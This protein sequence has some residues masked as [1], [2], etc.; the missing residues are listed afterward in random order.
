MKTIN[1]SI[2][3]NPNVGKTSVFNALTGLN[4]H[5][6]NYPGVTVEKKTGRFKTQKHKVKITDL[7]GVYSIYPSSVDEEVALKVLFDKENKNYPNVIVVVAE[8]ENLKR[9]LLLFSQVK[10][11]GIPTI[12]CLN[13]ADQ[14]EKKG[15]TL[16]IEALKKELNTPIVLVSAKKNLGIDELKNEID[17]YTAHS[18]DEVFS[19]SE[20]NEPFFQNLNKVYGEDA[21]NAWL[22]IQNLY[23]D[24]YPTI[25]V[26]NIQVSEHEL[27]RLAHKETIKRYQ[28]ISELLKDSYSKDIEIA[29]D[30]RMKFDRVMT[31]KFFGLLIFMVIMFIVFASIFELAQ[32]PMDFIDA[33]FSD[34]SSWVAGAL[35]EGKINDLITNGVIPGLSGVLMF[36]P[37]IAIL[38][39]LISILE[40]TGYMSRVVFLMDKFMRPFGLNGK[41]VV[42]LISG[43]ACA[44]PAIMSARNIE[45]STERL[46]TMLITPFTTCSAR[47]PVYII[48]I[49]LII[50][51]QNVLGFIPLQG[52]VLTLMYLLGFLGALGSAFLLSKLIKLDKKSVFIIE[53]PT[54]KFPLLKN[55]A[56]NIYEKVISYING[57]GKIILSLSVILWFLG[58]HGPEETFGRAEEM[59]AASMEQ[60]KPMEEAAFSN[61][62]ASYQLENSYIGILG[63]T[64]EPV[65]RP[66][67]Y[68]WKISIAVLTSFAAR[69]VFVANLATIYSLSDAEENQERIIERMRSEVRPDGSPT[70]SFATGVSL[71]MFYAFAMQCLSTVAITRKETYSWKWT[72]FQVAF[73]STFAYVVALL[74]FQILS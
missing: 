57:A 12:L 56:L 25:D 19:L 39:L 15:I 16:N 10:N 3:G 48:I 32:V 60:N 8:I 63:K 45:N 28:W 2:I 42:P 6:G 61:A 65:F 24:N 26:S 27:K 58:S 29:T 44:I 59:V 70:F 69:E 74:A 43:T 71:L 36:V 33:K 7:P 40:E 51:Q 22:K 31:H 46:I 66:L 18:C 41:S 64:I 34:F 17:A 62:V 14:I 13:M 1:V 54:Y 52:L 68:D 21:Y 11:L 23:P 5:T 30:I 20:I 73:M 37:Q 55:V 4:Q 47:I 72:L 49:T 38:F 35:P 50:P 53:M 9:N 67:G